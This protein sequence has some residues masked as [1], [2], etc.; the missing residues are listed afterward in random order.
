[1]TDKLNTKLFSIA[2][3]LRGSMDSDKYKDYILGFIFYKYLSDKQYLYA[4]KLLENEDIK[5]YYLIEESDELIGHIKQ[6]SIRQLGYFLSPKSLIQAITKKGNIKVEGKLTYILDDLQ[7]IFIDIENT[8]L[9]ED[10]EDDFKGLFKSIELSDKATSLGNNAEERHETIVMILNNLVDIDFQLDSNESDILGDAYE[11]L[12]K[13]F[14]A[15]AG[16]KGGEFYTPQEVSRILAKIVTTGKSRLRNAYDPTTGSG[17]LLLRITKEIEVEDICGQEKNNTTYN[18]ARMNMIM[19]NVHYSKFDIRND[20]TL[21][22]P[23]H[24]NETFEAI[25]A[26]PPFS[27]NWEGEDNPLFN[28]DP[29]FSNYGKL[30]SKS[31]ADYAFIEHMIYHLA[32]NG[33]MACVAPHGTLFKNYDTDA[34]RYMIDTLNCIDAVIGLPANLFFGVTIPV[35]ILVF[36]KCRKDDDNILFIDA[37]QHFEKVKN[38]NRLRDCDIDKIVSTY[39]ERKEEDKYSCKA[40]LQDVR[41]NEY[42]LNIPRYVDTF[43]EEEPI[44]LKEVATAIYALENDMQS[45]NEEIKKG[46]DE[47]GILTP[48]RYE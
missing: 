39:R 45:I 5:D 28:N 7:Q 27:L 47:L 21:K 24:I 11:Y 42:N 37:S 9:G 41:D 1:M 31:C 4:T 13:N 38:K 29:R 40:S 17:S 33:I 12:I 19:H 18:L 26:N 30:P 22:H 6:L 20:D 25:V 35:C 48:F 3:N 46:C 16:K 32:D 10:S 15:N 8:T 36:K 44:D 23:L 43:E 2:S 14:A 34:R